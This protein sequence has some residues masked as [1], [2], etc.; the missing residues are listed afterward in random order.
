MVFPLQISGLKFC[1]HF[2]PAQGPLYVAPRSLSSIYSPSQYLVTCTNSEGP[3]CVTL[4]S[5][6]SLKCKYSNEYFV[7]KKLTSSFGIR[8][9]V[10]SPYKTPDYLI[11]FHRKS[12]DSCI[13]SHRTIFRMATC[14]GSPIILNKPIRVG[15]VA[16]TF[17]IEDKRDR[18][19]SS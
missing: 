9:G 19:C 4:S 16:L 10:S 8:L 12:A 14:A 15:A 6:L 7:L 2:L 1:M 13:N 17:Y 3:L 11:V 5:L 18:R